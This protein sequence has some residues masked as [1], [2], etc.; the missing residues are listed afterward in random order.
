MTVE[1]IVREKLIALG[2]DGLC[3]PDSECGCPVDDLLCCGSC[4]G[5]CVPARA[6]GD[7]MPDEIVFVPLDE[8]EA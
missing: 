3:D 5:Q 4:G 8:S 6:M 7:G 1:D 2:A